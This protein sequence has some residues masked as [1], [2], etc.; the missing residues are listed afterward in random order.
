MSTDFNDLSTEDRDLRLTALLLGEV[1]SSHA[2]ELR[3]V[4]AADPELTRAYEARKRT[5]E[6]LRETVEGDAG[7]PAEAPKH[8]SSERRE[9]LLASFRAKPL[10]TP[11]QKRKLSLWFIPMSA[12]AGLIGL[13]VVVSVDQFSFGKAKARAQRDSPLPGYSAAKT[14]QSVEFAITDPR[15]SEKNFKLA[16]PLGGDAP[17]AT[18]DRRYALADSDINGRLGGSMTVPEDR[19]KEQLAASLQQRVILP[20]RGENAEIAQGGVHSVKAVGYVN[21]GNTV[22]ANPVPGAAPMAPIKTPQPVTLGSELNFE[23]KIAPSKAGELVQLYD[24]GGVTPLN[25][26]E[27]E[28]R[29]L[30]RSSSE[31]GK[32]ITVPPARPQTAPVI[33]SGGG[34]GGMAV[35]TDT[36]ARFSGVQNNALAPQQQVNGPQADTSTALGLKYTENAQ[37]SSVDLF[38]QSPPMSGFAID[39][40]KAQ[41]AQD[42]KQDAGRSTDFTYANGAIISTNA[43]YAINGSDWALKPPTWSDSDRDGGIR[44]DQQA[45]WFGS[46]VQR[47]FF[48]DSLGQSQIATGNS[49][50]ESRSALGERPENLRAVTDQPSAEVDRLSVLAGRAETPIQG[51]SGDRNKAIT[52]PSLEGEALADVEDSTMLIEEQLRR[53][54]GFAGHAG[55]EPASRQQLNRVGGGART[56]EGRNFLKPSSSGSGAELLAS[57]LKSE[58]RADLKRELSSSLSKK[59]ADG[60]SP[61]PPSTPAPALPTP[62][63]PAAAVRPIVPAP[64][65]QPE[66]L[67]R[68]TAF[69]TFS[70]NVAD[71]SFKLAAASLEK[72]AMPEAANIRAEE[73]L[74]AFDYRDPVPA[75]GAAVSFAWERAQFPFAQNR[76][77]L[78]FSVKTAAAG[79]DG[80]RPLNIVLLL[81]ASGSM[82]R[83]DRVRIIQEGLRTLATQLQA[84]DKISVVTFARTARLWVDGVSGTNAAQVAQRVSEITPEG[85]TNLEDALDLAYRTATRHYTANAINRVVLLTDGAANLGDVEPANLKAK[86]ESNRKQG[87][88]LDCFGVGWEGFNDDLLEQLSRNG[89][90][91]YGFINSP[92]EAATEFVGQL[93]GALRVAASDVKVQVEFNP[94]RVSAYRQVGYAKHQLTK[95]QFRDNKVDAAEIGASEAGNGLYVIETNP[96]GEGPIATVRVRYR[97]P[98]TSDYREQEWVVP[99]TPA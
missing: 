92:E 59:L 28:L 69:S 95:E 11:K 68:E 55:N 2:E 31:A 86:V 33:G 61:V 26:S 51:R 18:R 84:Q 74:N 94:K 47:G 70:L 90:G 54:D 19:E 6:L 13:L 16:L 87:I 34:V 14:E 48:D 39:G 78:R 9:K 80:G 24:A 42:A 85:G 49:R 40:V 60:T 36:Y 81:D 29:E 10:V 21:L 64:V 22:A 7:I 77:V 93:A 30:N 72:G 25:R 57:G 67:T 37:Q 3:R 23:S 83:A 45:N 50:L 35:A 66:V 82:E 20:A 17:S 79:R 43:F 32:P 44:A 4:I 89:D 12:A 5:L 91:R 63:E 52:L 41:V 71:V 46:S 65:P 1:P 99:F 53:S 76:D 75:P 98:N 38:I 56:L 15:P 27:G 96:R 73:F 58:A 88:A 8:L 97:V 62:G